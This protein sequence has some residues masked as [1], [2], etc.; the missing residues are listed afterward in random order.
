[1]AYIPGYKTTATLKQGSKGE[2]VK[3]LQ[4]RLHIGADGVFGSQ[5]KSAVQ[6]FQRSKKISADGIAGKQT[7]TALGMYGTQPNIGPNP[8]PGIGLKPP[9][10]GSSSG[11]SSSGSGYTTGSASPLPGQFLDKLIGGVILYGIYKTFQKIF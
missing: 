4:Y 2:A 10:G 6:N 5:T 1:M 7:L 11:G 8:N 9:G 3:Q